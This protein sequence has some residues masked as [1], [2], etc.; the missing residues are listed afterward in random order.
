MW[1]IIRSHC[2]RISVSLCLE[3]KD[4]M[5]WRMNSIIFLCIITCDSWILSWRASWSDIGCDLGFELG[6][7]VGTMMVAPVGY[8]LEDSIGMLLG[9]TLGTSFETWEIYLV[10]ISLGT[11]GGWMIG[12]GEGSL[13]VLSLGLPPVSPLEYPNNVAVLGSLFGYF[14]GMILRIYLVNSLVSLL[15]SIWHIN[16]CGTLL[17]TWKLL[18]HV[19]WVPNLL[20]SWICTWH[21]DFHSYGILNY[22]LSGQ[23]YWGI[24]RIDSVI[25]FGSHLGELFDS[26]SWSNELQ[27]IVW[28]PP[29]SKVR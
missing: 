12:T 24:Y 17:V 28:I 27:L 2:H 9:L 3:D 5:I 13:F 1:D 10:W 11:L 7:S 8:P 20:F 19:N 26:E 25:L 6:L 23:V 18:W 16:W 29:G 14:S 21:T 4:K 22:Q 15:G